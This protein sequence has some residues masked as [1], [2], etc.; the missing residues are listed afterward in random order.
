MVILHYRLILCLG[1]HGFLDHRA[2]ARYSTNYEVVL[3]KQGVRTSLQDA[4]PG[5]LGQRLV[6]YG[7]ASGL[8]SRINGIGL[9]CHLGQYNDMDMAARPRPSRITPLLA[10]AKVASRQGIASLQLCD[11]ADA[12]PDH[13]TV[14]STTTRET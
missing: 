14:D 5:H 1:T 3:V 4:N 13:G 12:S 10:L 9:S 6:S 11:I 2:Y 7:N 8:P